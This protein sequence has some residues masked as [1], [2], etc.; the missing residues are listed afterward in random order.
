MIIIYQIEDLAQT[1][2]AFKTETAKAKKNIYW[3][4]WT[5]YAG[6]VAIALVVLVLVIIA[7]KFFL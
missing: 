5:S 7:I 3:M 4:K 6:A 2:N 1:S